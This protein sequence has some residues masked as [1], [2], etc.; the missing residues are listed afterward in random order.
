MAN[1]PEIIVKLP[2]PAIVN[3]SKG[4]APNNLK[5]RK[6]LDNITHQLCRV[7]GAIEA[8]IR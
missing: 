3:F 6:F 7:S 2:T 5:Y 4:Q 8:D 1:R